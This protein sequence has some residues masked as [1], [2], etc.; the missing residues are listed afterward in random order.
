[1]WVFILWSDCKG[2]NNKSTEGP[3]N[4]EGVAERLRSDVWHEGADDAKCYSLHEHSEENQRRLDW[5]PKF[6]RSNL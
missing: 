1:M 5:S 6:E 2:Q 4:S 3:L